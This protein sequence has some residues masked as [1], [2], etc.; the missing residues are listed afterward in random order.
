[1]QTF[2]PQSSFPPQCIPSLHAGEQGGALQTPPWQTCEPHW[3]LL[4][5]AAPS[6]QNGKHEAHFPAVQT[7]DAQSPL[8]AHGLPSGQVGLHTAP[9]E[10]PAPLDES[11]APLDESVAPLDDG[12]SLPPATSE[13]A[14]SVPLL[15]APPS[16]SGEP[17]CVAS[18][19]SPPSAPVGAYRSKS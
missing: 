6:T 17:G 7:R 5:H 18:T 2:E 19:S 12:A 14:V 11:G 3:L 1:V 8:P 13:V 16:A 15:L 4:V 10:S 9:D